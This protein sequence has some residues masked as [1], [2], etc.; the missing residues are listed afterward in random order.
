MKLQHKRDLWSLLKKD[1]RNDI[2]EEA[3]IEEISELKSYIVLFRVDMVY[4][5]SDPSQIFRCKADDCEHAEEQCLN[6]YPDAN[7]ISVY[8]ED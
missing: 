7:I 6:A 8:Q 3:Y 4:N 5:D 2:G 1:I